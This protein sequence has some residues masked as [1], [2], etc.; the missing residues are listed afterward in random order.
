[1]T[2]TPLLYRSIDDYLGPS[3]NRFFGRG[4]R[5]AGHYVEDV[6]VTPADGERAGTRASVSVAYP[7][8]WSTKASRTDLRPHLSTVDTLV[9][10]VQ[11][12]EAY[13]TYA[14][15][16]DDAQRRAMR[17]R[18]VTLRAGG[19]PQENLAGLSAAAALASTERDPGHPGGFVSVFEC[20]VGAMRARCEIEHTITAHAANL[21]SCASLDH[22][23]GQAAAR[24]YGDGFKFRSQRIEHV[25]ANMTDLRAVATVH[26]ATAA[27]M[28]EPTDG[29]EGQYQPL[30][31][32]IDC[33]VVNLQLVQMLLYE[34][35]SVA[36]EDSNTLW[37]LKTV[38]EAGE[39]P[40]AYDK[41]LE[42][43]ASIT[44]K[45]LVPLRG[46]TWRNVDVSAACGGIRLRC[47]FAHELPASAVPLE[48]SVPGRL[49][50][51]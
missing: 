35:D 9:L 17:L 28:P 40:R 41:P 20:S 30:L 24:Y 8:D 42:T 34:M 3:D 32:M 48:N 16:L 12:S 46:G 43:S 27:G 38:L 50:A 47:S 26:I 51:K 21:H 18:K 44:G 6:V 36:R 33:F 5:R 49:G 1:V 13:L 4:Y 14:C 39:P 2:Q 37:M 29:I 10:G 31:S 19:E 23:L 15:G 11:L 25:A 45:H 7:D 22:L